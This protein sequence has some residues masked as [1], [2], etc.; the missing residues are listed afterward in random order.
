[1]DGDLVSELSWKVIGKKLNSATT[2]VHHQVDS[3]DQF[4]RTGVDQVIDAFNPIEVHHAVD[5]TSRI[6]TISVGRSS[7]GRPITHDKH[8][9]PSI[10]L[11][12]D[13]ELRNLTY[14]S[15]I[16]VDFK[17]TGQTVVEGDRKS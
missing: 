8:G 3:F 1:M 15:M 16:H 5:N 4:V 13:A 10:V 9:S 14:C 6:Y 2:L 17:I 7:I 11:P 12:N